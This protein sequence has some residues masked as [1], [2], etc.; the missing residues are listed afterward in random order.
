MHRRP[1]PGALGAEEAA[2]QDNGGAA[3]SYAACRT[4]EMH[5]SSVCRVQEQ[6]ATLI[7]AER[8]A[9][10]SFDRRRVKREEK[11]AKLEEEVGA[12]NRRAVEAALRGKQLSD[13]R[14]R[15]ASRPVKEREAAA[16]AAAQAA[17]GKRAK[18]L[19]ELKANTEKAQRQLRTENERRMKREEAQAAARAVEAEA[20]INQ[21]MLLL[22]TR[23]AARGARA[24]GRARPGARRMFRGRWQSVRGLPPA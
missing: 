21:G 16:Q 20:I 14:V 2:L 23:R 9:A 11:L 5:V 8:R 4:L 3:P 17:H 15:E 7:T 22:P 19:L 18:A 13:V 1:R 24:A 12:H 10:Y 6:A